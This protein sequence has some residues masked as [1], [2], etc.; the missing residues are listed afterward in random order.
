MKFDVNVNVTVNLYLP[1]LSDA[2]TWMDNAS[3]QLG[4]IVQSQENIMALIDDVLAKGDAAIAA[5]QKNTD[6]DNSIIG[7]LNAETATIADLKTALANAGTDPA[8]LQALSDT[9]DKII[10]NNN[11]NAQ[12]K[13]DAITANTPAA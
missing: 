10:Q 12:K 13:A 4:V 1:G 2:Q 11:D 9:M 7:M 3:E 8:K 5:T 6:L